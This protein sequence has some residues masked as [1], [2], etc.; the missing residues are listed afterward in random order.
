MQLRIISALVLI[1][2]RVNLFNIKEKVVLLL[3][4]HWSIVKYLIQEPG[5]L[6][7]LLA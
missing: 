7:Y 3:K 4:T 2:H 6:G 1:S 5:N